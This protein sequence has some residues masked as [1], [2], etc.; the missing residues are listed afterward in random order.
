MK[1][2]KLLFSVCLLIS[3]FVLTQTLTISSTGET[4]T[5]G[6]GW[7]ITGSTL[8]VTATANISASV[9]T[10]AMTNGNLTIVPSVTSPYNLSVTFDEAIVSNTSGSSLTIG[11]STPNN[12]G[13]IDINASITVD[14]A[15]NL[16]AQRVSIDADITTTNTTS[17]NILVS[18]SE[19]STSNPAPISGN[20]NIN[21]AAGKD[22]TF[23]NS[24]S[25]TT[26]VY[27]GI[28]SGINSRFL[29]SGSG[30]VVLTQ[31]NLFSGTTTI[32]LGK[33]I[34]R[35]DNPNPTSKTFS[36]G[37]TIIIE[38]SSSR[39]TNM[40]STTGY[41]FGATN[42]IIGKVD[43]DSDVTISDNLSFTFSGS[44][45]IHC[46]TLNLNGNITGTHGSGFFLE[47]YCKNPM[48]NVTG[49]KTIT[50][51]SAL[52]IYAP[53][54]GFS[55]DLTFPIPNLTTTQLHLYLGGNNNNKNI[56]INSNTSTTGAIILTGDKIYLNG[57]LASTNN[58]FGISLTTNE[59]I[60]NAP[61]TIT[62][63]KFLNFT[64][65]STAFLSDIVFPIPN[66]TVSCNGLFI[67]SITNT[68]NIT[69]AT[70]LSYTAASITLYGAN[71]Y[72][73]GNLNTISTGS[74][75]N[76][77]DISLKGIV[78]VAP[79]KYIQCGRN[80]TQNGDITF[81]SDA[82]GTAM[83]GTLGGTYTRSSGS[84]I[85][86]RYIPARRAFRFL[87][88]SVTTTTSIKTNWQENGGT[89]AGLGTHITGANGA[90]NGFD[91]TATNNPS[92]YTFDNGA[93]SAVTNTNTNVLTAGSPY[94]LMVRGD[95][96][97]D[98]ST[99]TPNA[100]AT[101][102]RA[103][104][105]L[106]TGN[107][108]PTLNSS[109]DG[110]SLVGNPYQAPIDIK[111][112][113]TASTNM[114]TN[115][116]YYW[117]PTLN[118]RGGYVTRDLTSDVNDVTSSF[119]QYVQPGQA[120]FVKK[121]NTAN[122]PTMT[123][124]EA[125]KSIANAGAGVFRQSNATDSG[126]IRA[127]LQ[128]NINNQWQTTDATLAVFN[129]DYSWNVTQEDATKMSNL[130]E[131]VSFIQN[132][133]N[134]AIAKQNN[135]SNTSELPIKI[136]KLRHTVYQWQFE[137]DNYNGATPY[138]Y[139]TTNNSYTQINNGTV[140]PFTADLN[141]TNRFKIVFQSNALATDDFVKNIKLYPN[142]AKAGASFYVDGITEAT[143][144]VYN[145]LGQNIPVTV[146]SQGSA[147]QVIPETTLSQGVYLVTVTTEGKTAQ[148][149]WIV[150]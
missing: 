73:N 51:S 148:V 57:N 126:F 40:F 72:L 59:L 67:G 138:L 36:G 33:L 91:A 77:G 88:P 58:N 111:A 5:S 100:T 90:T 85:S 92:I 122:V 26:S 96:T 121:D 2:K 47:I 21:I 79:G 74:S 103:T 50:L 123:I 64:P 104:G 93:W 82:T 48:I 108:T 134:L 71:L 13:I 97:T 114:S 107:Y 68:K 109:A 120:V 43:N 115:V 34:L 42:L 23:T 124:T 45:K 137:L 52:S 110:F 14:G 131:E 99:N 142:P 17:G 27:G 78:T 76:N 19:S 38:P 55:S 41:S 86:E 69:I 3:N 56:I 125:N 54:T 129:E 143:V 80:F 46:N 30:T 12:T 81:K 66:L 117:D 8:T 70:D 141:T 49:T 32:G 140:V 60:V 31:N 119:T 98:L 15:I 101:T 128:A 113:L 25:A 39:F 53:T 83:F 136:D 4:G 133:T 106:K 149:K 6:T 150:E 29:T 1:I 102:L 61:Q 116:V 146:K 44:M 84:V 63:A 132:N 87:S 94:R 35:N 24:A 105:T 22:L 147:I 28:I 7:S 10:T 65:K 127:N 75:S 130:D 139:D 37:G 9:I 62:T 89:T 112:I 144:S 20:G 95:R 11:S 135:P 16:Y 118:A 145:I 18:A